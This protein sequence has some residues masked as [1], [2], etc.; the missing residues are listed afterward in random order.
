MAFDTKAF[1]QALG[2]FPTGVAV[3][4]A[5]PARPSLSGITVN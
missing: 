2:G 5:P 1:R 3:V 4:T